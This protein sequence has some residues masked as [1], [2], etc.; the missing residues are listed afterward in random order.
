MLS[1]LQ[2]DVI[3]KAPY[4]NA[5]ELTRNAP[6]GSLHTDCFMISGS[7]VIEGVGKYV[8][9]AVETRSF[10]GRVIMGMYPVD[11]DSRS[12]EIL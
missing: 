6:A 12:T 8:V 2:Q 3:K 11:V 9:V 10:N 1:L 4:A 5:V 7:K